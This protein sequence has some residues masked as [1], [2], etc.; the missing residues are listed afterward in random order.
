MHA[1]DRHLGWP[2]VGIFALF[3]FYNA[4]SAGQGARNK[5]S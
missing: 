5:R 1:E 2:E 3:I 4:A